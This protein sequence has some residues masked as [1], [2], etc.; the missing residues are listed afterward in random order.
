MSEI[1]VYGILGSPFVRGVQMLLEEKHA[2]YRTEATSPAS[3]K[4]AEHLKRHP[5]GRVPAIERGEFSQSEIRQ[6]PSMQRTQ[7]PEALQGG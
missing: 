4:T 7:R 5:F 3:R 1:V 6:R 2:P